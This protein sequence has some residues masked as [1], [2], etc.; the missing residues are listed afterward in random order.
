MFFSFRDLDP[1]NA[2]PKVATEPFLSHAQKSI[3]V[4]AIGTEGD[5]ESIEPSTN[6]LDFLSVQL[7]STLAN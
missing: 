1:L 2:L 6:M 4:P 5:D 7:T 3:S